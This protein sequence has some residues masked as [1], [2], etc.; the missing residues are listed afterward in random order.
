MRKWSFRIEKGSVAGPVLSH[1][2]PQEM[3]AADSAFCQDTLSLWD[4]WIHQAG[5]GMTVICNHL[6]VLPHSGPLYLPESVGGTVVS[7][8][9]AAG[10][11]AWVRPGWHLQRLRGCRWVFPQLP[12]S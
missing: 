6:L 2:D 7:P 4:W 9:K 11:G 10:L 5:P 1:R 12:H 3:E 8:Q